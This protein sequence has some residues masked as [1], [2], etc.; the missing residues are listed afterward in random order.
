MLTRYAIAAACLLLSL[1]LVAQSDRST[2]AGNQKIAAAGTP[3][4]SETQKLIGGPFVVNATPTSATVVWIVEG[5]EVTFRPQSGAASSASPV[6]QVQKTSLTGLTPNTQYEYA[7]PGHEEAKGS[8]KT[9]PSPAKPVP[10]RFFL[11]GD[12]RTRHDVHRRVISQVLKNDAPDFI[13]HTG[14]LVENGDDSTLWPI[15]F[16]IEKNLLR[17]T[18]F[19]PSLGNHERNTRYFGDFFQQDTPYY[20]FDWANAHFIVLNSDI[21]NAAASQRERDKFWAEQTSWLADDLAT[22]QKADYRFVIAHHPP[23]TAVARRQGDNPHMT[24]LMPMFEKYRVSAAMF[25]HDHNYQHYLKNGIHYVISGGGGAPLYDVDQP[26]AGI[27]VKVASI[28]NFVIVSVNG[29]TASLKVVAIDGSTLDE[30]EIHGSAQ[31]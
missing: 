25:G 26:P 9:P 28:E 8:F 23:I 12:T 6:L 10:F 21:A 31:P 30:F 29:K 1:S 15:F 19:Y 16:D 20:S 18:V 17:Q 4:T 3:L 27:T 24:A 7:V 11:Y 13:L 14:D 2:A 5:G 22:H